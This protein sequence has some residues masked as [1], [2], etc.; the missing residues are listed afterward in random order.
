MKITIASDSFKGSAS[1]LE[2]AKAMERGIHRVD[3]TVICDKFPVADGGEGLI[4]T[5]QQEGDEEVTITVHGPLF[6]KRQASYLRRGKLAIIEMATA[7]GLPLVPISQRN[8]MDTTSL[9]TGELILDALQKGCDDLIVGIGGSATND[10]GIGM[11]TAL[12]ALFYDKEGTIV[13][14]TGKNI[15]SIASIDT[16]RMHPALAN[17]K[18]RVACD[19]DNPLCGPNGAS[20]IYGPQKGATPEMV[21]ILDSAMDTFSKIMEKQELADYPG[22]GAAGGLGFALMTFANAQLESGIA[23]VLSVIGMEESLK[24]ATLCF[25]G[26][27]KIDGQSKCGK[28]P[29]GIAKLAKKYNVP[30]IAFA[31][32]IGNGTESLYE[33]GINAIVSTTNAAMPLEKAM[34]RSL[35]LTEDAAFRTFHLIRT[36]MELRC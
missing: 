22:A 16:S 12:G 20:A 23:L 34:A 5:L 17:A 13:I 15:S 2:V 6:E 21:A 28:V 14:P 32:D 30:V 36:C 35:E 18:I 33:L 27:G 7:S 31:G 1:S 8:P 19:V 11:A 24:S 29:V 4:A 10:C 3:P 9:G 26:E 25:T